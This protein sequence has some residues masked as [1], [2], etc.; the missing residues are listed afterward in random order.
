MARN[1]GRPNDILPAREFVAGVKAW[2][3]WFDNDPLGKLHYIF[4][5]IGIRLGWAEYHKWSGI[6]HK[7]KPQ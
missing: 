4:A 3:D 6:L 5:C 2:G 1:N 7:G